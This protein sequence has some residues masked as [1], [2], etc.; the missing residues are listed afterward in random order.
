M[1]RSLWKCPC[2]RRFYGYHCCQSDE[3]ALLMA[4][5]ADL[6]HS[7][8]ARVMAVL[9]LCHSTGH[10]VQWHRSESAA[11]RQFSIPYIV[12][13]TFSVYHLIILAKHLSVTPVAAAE[14]PRFYRARAM[15]R[16][17]AEIDFAMIK[18]KNLIWFGLSNLSCMNN[19]KH[20]LWKWLV[21]TCK[22]KCE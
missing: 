10:Y 15:R 16:A 9:C 7:T 19:G 20:S 12:L 21:R 2:A 22:Q 13:M 8:M 17:R 4:L 6:C 11:S 3:R 1:W 14:L 5:S 18:K